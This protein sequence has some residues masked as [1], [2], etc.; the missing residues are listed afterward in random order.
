MIAISEMDHPDISI[1]YAMHQVV[2]KQ[3]VNTKQFK[4]YAIICKLT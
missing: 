1:F 2:K 3:V 4:E